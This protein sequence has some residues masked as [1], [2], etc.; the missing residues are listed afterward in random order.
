L[1]KKKSFKQFEENI[2]TTS[3]LS[4]HI[5][6]NITLYTCKK[7]ENENEKIGNKNV[8]QWHKH[9]KKICPRDMKAAKI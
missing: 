9:T 3:F 1:R 2:K 5:F 8:E 6:A 7:N 4:I